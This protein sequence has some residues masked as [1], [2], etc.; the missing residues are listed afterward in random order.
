VTTS[1]PQD[2]G[3][4][5]KNSPPMEVTLEPIEALEAVEDCW[6]R[7]YKQT[8]SQSFFLSWAWVGALLRNTPRP[9]WPALLQV[10]SGASLIALGLLGASTTWRHRWLR[11]RGLHLN[12]IGDPAFDKITIEH[13]GLLCR[14]GM[15][16]DAV[17]AVLRHLMQR[18]DWDELYLSGVSAATGRAWGTAAN[19]FGLDTLD[20]SVQPHFSIDLEALR[21]SQSSFL[22]SLSANTR[23]QINRSKKL[24]AKRGPLMLYHASS[25]VE[26]RAWF[27]DLVQLHQ[28]YW[29]AR[30]SEGAFGSAFTRAFHEDLVSRGHADGSVEVV[31]VSA[32]PGVVGYL[33][34]FRCG[35]ALYNYQSALTYESENKLKPGLVCHSMAADDAL[36]RGLHSYDLLAGGEHYKS[37][38]ATAYASMVWM[39]LQRQRLGFRLERVLRVMKSRAQGVA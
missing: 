27:D 39:S 31:K 12:E 1:I 6:T 23:Y 7:L 4:A 17:S 29:Q 2:I 16:L 25:A 38:L 13:S 14:A 22:E 28:T 20:R 11:S 24:Y 33:Y 37:N 21:A 26:A 15:E 34:N 3:A 30:G 9:R 32:G 10:R 18:S 35:L 19:T 8:S 36:S 5:S